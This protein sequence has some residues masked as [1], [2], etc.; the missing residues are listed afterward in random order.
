MKFQHTVLSVCFCGVA[1]HSYYNDKNVV[2]V[3]LHSVLRV[4]MILIEKI[5]L[6]VLRPSC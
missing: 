5:L 1:H 6:N 4:I 2:C 3:C